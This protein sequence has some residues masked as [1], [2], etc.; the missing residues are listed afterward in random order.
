MNRLTV[1]TTFRNCRASADRFAAAA[2]FTG[3]ISVLCLALSLL[4]ILTL[5]LPSRLSL[6]HFLAV[7]AGIAVL[8]GIAVIA[9]FWTT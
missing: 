2:G 5:L 4:L 1:R 7:I 3:S 6:V 8:I 9:T